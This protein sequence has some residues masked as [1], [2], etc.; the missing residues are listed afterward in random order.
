MIRINNPKGKNNRSYLHHDLTRHD[1]LAGANPA[2]S[3]P[4]KQTLL[5]APPPTCVCAAFG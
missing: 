5:S 1:S 2:L 3:F 4:T